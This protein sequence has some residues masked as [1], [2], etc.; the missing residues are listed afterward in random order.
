MAPFRVKAPE[1][2]N[3]IDDPLQDDYPHVICNS[4]ALRALALIG[5]VKMDVKIR[6]GSG[7]AGGRPK[8]KKM[9]FS[10]SLSEREFI[11]TNA[12]QHIFHLNSQNLATFGVT[13]RR[14]G[15]TSATLWR[16]I[17]DAWRHLGDSWAT[18]VT[19]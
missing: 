16:W 3:K 12:L 10:V 13:L 2:R 17:G 11:K 9:I 19:I 7:T 4:S 6:A 18:G 14:F 5:M 8:I 1:T 15:V